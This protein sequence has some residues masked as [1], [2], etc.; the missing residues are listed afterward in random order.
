[1][2][3]F[4][5]VEF[6]K[7]KNHMNIFVLKNI[8]IKIYIYHFLINI[9]TSKLSFV[10]YVVVLNNF[11]YKYRKIFLSIFNTQFNGCAARFDVI[12]IFEKFL[13]FRYS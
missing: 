10:N 1:M 3:N 6:E 8:F 12:K 9:F 11:L 7:C 5:V 13:D 4:Y 2:N